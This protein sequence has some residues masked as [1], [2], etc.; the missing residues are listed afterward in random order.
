VDSDLQRLDD[1]I[2]SATSGMKAEEL[3]HHPEGK[4]CAAEIL[5]HLYL[6]YTAT[7]KGLER[8]LQQD[9]PLAR[10][11]TLKDRVRTLV[12]TRLN[13]FP[14]GHTSPKHTAPKGMPPEHVLAD[15]GSKVAAMDEIIARCQA[16][17]GKATQVLDHP[18]LGPL[19]TQQWCRFHWVHGKHHLK[20]IM[21]LKKQALG[22]GR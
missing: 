20:Q 2:R 1:T 14:S 9:K 21:R 11:R 7:T 18:I 6:T 3:A 4:W 16:R 8:C 17:F 22:S 12:V 10:A 5:E 15:I 19:T 13:Y